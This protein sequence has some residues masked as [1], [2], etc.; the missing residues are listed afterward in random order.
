MMLGQ[1]PILA[2][3]IIIYVLGILV[4]CR[5]SIQRFEKVDL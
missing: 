3:G 2:A 5:V 4:A 1:L